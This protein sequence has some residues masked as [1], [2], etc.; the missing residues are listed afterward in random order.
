[1]PTTPDVPAK[2]MQKWCHKDVLRALGWVEEAFPKSK[3]AFVISPTISEVQYGRSPGAIDE[4]TD[5]IRTSLKKEN[6]V[7]VDFHGIVDDLLDVPNL[8]RLVTPVQKESP[9]GTVF[10]DYVH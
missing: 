4:L 7:V 10:R 8:L 3:V 1:M 9:D 6:K 2:K 5:C